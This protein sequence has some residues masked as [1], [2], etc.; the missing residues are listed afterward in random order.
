MSDLTPF[1]ETVASVTQQFAAVSE[2]PVPFFLVVALVG[3]GI[4]KF[5]NHHYSGRISTKDDLLT[6]RQAQ[7]DDYKAKLDGATPDAA[8]ARMDALEARIAEIVPQITALGP[9]RLTA[10][11]QK[12]MLPI[13][14]SGR[15]AHITICSDAASADAA[16]FS[17]SLVAVFNSAGWIVRT[18]MVL[19]LGYSPPSGIGL[20]VKNPQSLSGAEKFVFDSLKAAGLEFDLLQAGAALP[21]ETQEVVELVITN[22]LTD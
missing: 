4:W 10:E 1:Q 22:K 3:F 8:K 15:G 13:L 19:G 21:I 12:A 9:R 6:L 20:R 2:A 14:D 7:I 16:Q 11:Q 18:P 17:R 5:L